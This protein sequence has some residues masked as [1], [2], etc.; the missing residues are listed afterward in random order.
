MNV[1]I[2]NWGNE[3]IAL[4][5]WCQEN[6]M[7][8]IYL[9]SVNTGWQSA[10]WEL[11]SQEG[12]E[13]AKLRGI[14][15]IEL[16]AIV[17]FSKMVIQ[18]AEFPS[19]TF[20]WCA[21]TLKKTAILQW[22]NEVDPRGQAKIFLPY[23]KAS[24]QKFNREMASEHYDCREIQLPLLDISETEFIQRIQAEGFEVLSTRS[25]ECWPCVNCSASELKAMDSASL[26]KLAHL[27]EQIGKTLCKNDQG[28]N[29]GI[30]DYVNASKE[31]AL[32]EDSLLEL[33]CADYFA[34]G[35]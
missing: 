29:W 19:P 30:L 21:G 22:L 18:R 4:L 27:E 6:Q 3:T 26:E 17:T 7:N 28:E 10:Q 32:I 23:R 15:V 8:D 25:Q 33:N 20:L 16:P 11:R 14:H 12:R 31:G 24:Y 9:V 2:G 5:S 35:K 13:Y 34:C 1:V